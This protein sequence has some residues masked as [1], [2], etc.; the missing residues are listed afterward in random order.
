MKGLAASAG[1]LLCNEKCIVCFSN[2]TINVKAAFRMQR[3]RHGWVIITIP[4]PCLPSVV[5]FRVCCVPGDRTQASPCETLFSVK[6]PLFLLRELLVWNIFLH[7]E[8]LLMEH[9]IQDECEQIKEIQLEAERR[10][11]M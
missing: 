8:H 4:F 11:M 2:A 3:K 6:L 5:S 10:Q 7:S 1:L 9:R